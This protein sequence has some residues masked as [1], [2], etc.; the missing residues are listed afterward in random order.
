MT[1]NIA[2]KCTYNDGLGN[3]NYAKIGFKG[4]CS[5]QIIKYNIE[6]GR[7]WCNISSCKRYYERS[8]R[9]QRPS[10]PC[11]ESNIFSNWEYDAGWNH[12]GV[13]GDQPRKIRKAGVGQLALLTTRFHNE[14]EEN[15]KIF[16]CYKIGNIIDNQGEAT[17]VIAGDEPK[18]KFSAKEAEQLSFWNY[19]S[20]NNAPNKCFWGTGLFRY[21]D[22]EIIPFLND[23]YDVVNDDKKKVKLIELLKHFSNL[24]NKPEIL[25]NVNAEINKKRV[26]VG[27]AVKVKD[28]FSDE[29]IEYKV[30]ST[31][32]KANPDKNV[33]SKESPIAKSLIN[34]ELEQIVE[35]EVPAGTIKHKILEIK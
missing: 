27:S 28:V 5:D 16:G 12:N 2:F 10:S 22:R 4:T 13:H 35:I 23:A 8:F 15:R 6:E 24:Y 29:I 32:K 20:N 26:N 18:I 14:S 1:R 25:E 21:M 30:V 7:S 33:I 9:G 17:R 34:S 31:T 19:Y 11:Y 3:G